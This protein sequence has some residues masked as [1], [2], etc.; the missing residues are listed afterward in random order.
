MRSNPQGAFMIGRH[1]FGLALLVT[2]AFSTAQVE[3]RNVPIRY[4][5]PFAGEDMYASYCS[6]CHGDKGKGDGPAAAAT[7]LPPGDLTTLSKSNHG[8]FP[9]AH[10]F[11]SILNGKARQK[12]EPGYDMPSWKD[13]FYSLCAGQRG[14]GAEVQMRIERLTDYLESL[15]AK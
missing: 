6:A 8:R 3:T 5:S 1:Y 12:G 14:C 2:A 9:R 10:V 15:Q 11:F 7:T 13:P 4:I